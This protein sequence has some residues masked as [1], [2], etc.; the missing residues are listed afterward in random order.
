MGKTGENTRGSLAGAGGGAQS[1]GRRKD[2]WLDQEERQYG[3]EGIQ[4]SI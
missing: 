1:R 3:G 2:F 4:P